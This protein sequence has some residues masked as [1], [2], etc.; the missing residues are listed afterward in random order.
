MVSENTDGSLQKMQKK[1][2]ELRKRKA[3]LAVY[4]ERCQGEISNCE[5]RNDGTGLDRWKAE[6]KKCIEEISGIDNNLSEIEAN[7]KE[8]AHSRNVEVSKLE[9]EFAAG[10]QTLTVGL[11][12]AEDA[13]DAKIA[14]NEERMDGLKELTSTFIT[15]ISKLS[16][17]RKSTISDLDKIGLPQVRRKKAQI[18]VPFFLA[19]Y[20][21]R[22]KNRY[23]LFPPSFVHGMRGVTKIKGVFRASKVTVILEERSR[24]ITKFMNLF[25]QLIKQN[26]MFEEK[27]IRAGAKV[28][29]LGTK[30]NRKNIAKG[31][32][33]LK[34]EGWLSEDENRSL[35]DQL[36]KS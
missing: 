31:L 33:I 8:I 16:D 20:K 24:S 10:S 29:V 34:D 21:Q 36:L 5:A 9:A 19:C 27:L 26:P 3:T 12:R 2:A 7:I 13:R 30:K 35:K 28:N 22:F 17:L 15:H 23:L 4:I 14:L 32:G 25:L 18:Y 6:L 11:K 1:G